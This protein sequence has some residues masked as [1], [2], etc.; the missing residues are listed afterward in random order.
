MLSFCRLYG[1]YKN[2]HF[3]ILLGNRRFLL[4]YY[5]GQT[6]KYTFN[7]I[8]EIAQSVYLYGIE[9]RFKN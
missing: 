6:E 4:D 9:A 8:L 2:N 7:R 5:R 1:N 3:T